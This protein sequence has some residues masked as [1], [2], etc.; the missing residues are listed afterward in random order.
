LITCIE[1]LISP[2]DDCEAAVVGVD[3]DHAFS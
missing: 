1:D 2:Q 3:S